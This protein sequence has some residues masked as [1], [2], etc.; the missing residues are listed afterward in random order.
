MPDPLSIAASVIS[1]T[2][3]AAQISSVLIKFTRQSKNAPRQAIIVLTEITEM[4][5]ILSHLQSF[6]LG[7]ETAG[8]S[9]ICFLQV[10]YV[11][12]IITGCVATF[13]ELEETL[14]SLKTEGM[15]ILDRIKWVRKESGI[16]A[17]IQRLQT[18]KA[19]LSLMLN[20]FNGYAFTSLHRFL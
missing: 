8:P 15:D 13:S 18:H 11:V 2:T 6:L 17:I 12:A 10:D 5:G 3:A 20:I 14:D 1:I 4:S 16:M 9:R 7:I 19:S